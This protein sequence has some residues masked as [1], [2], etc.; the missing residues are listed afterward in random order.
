M[1]IYHLAILQNFK[2]TF[3]N[4]DTREWIFFCV[5][6]FRWNG[7]EKKC[8]KKRKKVLRKGAGWPDWTNFRPFRDCF[9]LAV[10]WKLQKWATFFGQLFSTVKI[11]PQIR[12]NMDWATF[13]VIFSQTH[14]VTLERRQKEK[15]D[16]MFLNE[17]TLIFPPQTCFIVNH[18]SL[19]SIWDVY[20]CCSSHG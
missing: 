14:L 1:K 19:C 13:W 16:K 11:M 5:S 15:S 3:E 4:S 18:P 9:L 17:S 7:A 8:L 6:N 2:W 12:P 10:F 20:Q